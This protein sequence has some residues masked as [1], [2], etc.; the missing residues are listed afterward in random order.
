MTFCTAFGFPPDPV[1]SCLL[2]LGVIEVAGQH[3]L[4]RFHGVV[5]VDARPAAPLKHVIDEVGDC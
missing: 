5:N 3:V 1:G 4:Q 2:S